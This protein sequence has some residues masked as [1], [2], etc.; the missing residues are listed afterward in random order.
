MKKL[1][2][3]G[4]F[5]NSIT[6]FLKCLKKDKRAL[7]DTI[8]DETIA[9]YLKEKSGY[10][11]FGLVK[12]SERPKLIQKLVD[13]LA[14][15]VGRFSN[16]PDVSEMTSFKT[17]TR[18]LKEQCETIADDETG[19]PKVTLKASADVATDSLQNPSDPDATYSGHKGQGYQAQILETCQT[20]NGE[21]EA[22][23]NLILYVEVEGAHKHD[24]G[25]LVP[26]IE[27]LEEKG[28]KPDTILADIAYGSDENTEFAAGKGIE[29][30]S[31]VPGKKILGEGTEK[32]DE[33]GPEEEDYSKPSGGRF[34]LCDFQFDSEKR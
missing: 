16:D 5:V 25:A 12:P 2:R 9:F 20:E 8:S 13:D 31:P 32:S 27:K 11:C 30:V 10:D 17:L 6:K 7:F 19:K 18:I 3:S 1:M 15:L 24:G 29:L 23:P 4:L 22:K 14:Y 28:I 34:T 33:K 21:G 26:A